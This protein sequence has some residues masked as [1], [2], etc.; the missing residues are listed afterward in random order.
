MKM[1]IALRWKGIFCIIALLSISTI[2]VSGTE[3][4]QQADSAPDPAGIIS[5]DGMKIFGDLERPPVLFQHDR[6]TAAVQKQGKDCTVCHLQQEGNL[7]LLFKRAENSAPKAVM[8]LYHENCIAC[9]KETD[10]AKQPS[11]PVECGGCHVEKPTV[12]PAQQPAGMDKS[13]HF[14]HSKALENKC[15]SCHHEYDSVAKKLIYVKDAEGSCRFC[16]K[17]VT[18]ENRISI[19]LAAHKA[20]IGCHLKTASRQQKTGPFTCAGCH[21]AESRRLVEKISPVPRMERKQ[22]DVAMIKTG[23][24]QVEHR[25]NFTP[26]DHKAHE[27]YN[28][29]C[30]VCHHAGMQA[31]NTCHTMDGKKEGADIRLEQAMHRINADPSCIGCHTRQQQKRECAGCHALMSPDGGSSDATCAK[32][33]SAIPTADQQSVTPEE[34]KAAAAALL[35][36]RTFITGLPEEKDIPEK[37]VIKRMSDKYEPVEL[38]HRKIVKTLFEEIKDNK[39]AGYFHA[40]QETICQGCHHNSPASLNPPQCVSCHGKPFSDP[41]V[42][43]PGLLGAYHIQCMECHKKMEIDKPAT[44]TECHKKKN[45]N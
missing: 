2:R 22:P 19:S 14:R 15:D 7:L 9:H 39:L 38:P 26:F 12:Q 23:K 6:H 37:V 8:N 42:L 20:C 5:I 21:N 13:L 45:T 25:M 24:E 31:C 36:A 44:C 33:H 43:K 10:A 4:Q 40:R 30:R 18:E 34:E 35:G 17:Q 1:G 11:G 41:D 29:T 27:N 32:C 3:T 16:H 28:D